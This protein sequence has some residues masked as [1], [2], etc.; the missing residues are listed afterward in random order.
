MVHLPALA[1]AAAGPSPR[2]RVEDL[3]LEGTL[4]G[5]RI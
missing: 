2:V 3:P 5:W 4:L 1:A